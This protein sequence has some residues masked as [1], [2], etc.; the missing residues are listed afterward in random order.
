MSKISAELI[1][2]LREKTGVGMGKCKA[3]LEEAGGDLELAI[4]NLRK[5]GMASAVKKEGREA[6]EGSIGIG[7]SD[8]AFA[9]VEV[10]SETDFV[11]QNE[12][13]Q[14]FLKDV[15]HE[16][17]LT[18]PKD[19]ETFLAQKCHKDESLTIDEYRALI[20]QSLGENIQI[21]R[22]AVLPKDKNLSIG[23]YSHMG[24]RIVTAIEMTGGE[25]NEVLARDIAMHVAAEAP[26]YLSEEDVPAKIK[27]RE[28]DIAKSQV[29]GKPANIIDKIVA[30]KV[31]A[32]YDQFCL[33]RQKYIKDNSVT[34]EGLLKREGKEAGKSFGI[35]NFYRWQVGE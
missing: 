30:G 10:N 28:E 2:E 11:S 20:I 6:N 4:E 31:N 8:K 7:E 22:F 34:V 1:K 9:F 16:A 5:A 29:E 23:I 14:Q 18:M 13:F 27:A 24:G 33:L 12:K 3:A 15:A 25:G 17:A 21:K 35:K 32:Y 19:L 26:E